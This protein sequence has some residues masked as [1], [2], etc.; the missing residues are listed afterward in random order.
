VKQELKVRDADADQFYADL[1]QQDRL[2]KAHREELETQDQI[3]RNRST[4]EVCWSC[5][6]FVLFSINL[7]LLPVQGLPKPV[8]HLTNFSREVNLLFLYLL[9]NIFN[10]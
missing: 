9:Y 7:F 3:E 8:F 6:I 4:L 5:L 2:A 1:W 10:W